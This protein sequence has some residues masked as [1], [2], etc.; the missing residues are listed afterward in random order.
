MFVIYAW[1]NA[2]NQPYFVS[3]CLEDSKAPYR[4]KNNLPVPP[5]DQIQILQRFEGEDEALRYLDQLTYELGYEH[6]C[7]GTL[8]NSVASNPSS[9]R[10]S[11]S[12]TRPVSVYLVKDGTHLGDWETVKK[13]VET[14]R[15]VK[16]RYAVLWE[17]QNSPRMY[18]TDQGKPFDLRAR[19]RTTRPKGAVHPFSKPVTADKR[20]E[21]FLSLRTKGQ[22]RGDEYHRH[23]LEGAESE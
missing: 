4:P 12:N 15:S 13:P 17:E 1:L 14:F 5:R 11:V 2:D 20:Q 10:S 3:K 8:K 22:G 21:N 16:T 6:D 7:S 18:F 19:R 9:L 23:L